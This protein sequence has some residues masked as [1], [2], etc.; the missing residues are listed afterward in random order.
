MTTE[1]DTT[2]EIQRIRRVSDL[3]CTAHA[4]LR[5]K[6][7]RL[8]L[9]AEVVTL[10]SSTWLLAL[11]FVEP[12]INT[13]LTPMGLDP[14]IWIGFLSAATFFLTILQ[15]RTDWRG[16]ADAHARSLAMY[17]EVKRECGYL[18]TS[19]TIIGLAEC[20][21]LLARYDMAAD[22]C[23][24]VPERDFLRYK[25]RH[26]TKVAISRLL[27]SHPSAS[28]FLLRWRLWRRSNWPG[29]N[30]IREDHE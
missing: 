27:D 30:G 29:R 2:K 28:I 8:A 7:S 6:Y 17:A 11:V 25:K 22:L 24:A 15:V 10:A 14:P 26:L 1:A 4:R 3:L 16:K 12:R 9:V 19:G 13:R 5:D 20:Q 21:R 18:L 23:M